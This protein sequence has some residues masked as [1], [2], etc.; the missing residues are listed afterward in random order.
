[1][2]EAFDFEYMD[3]TKSET[4]P[5]K[6]RE[7]TISATSLQNFPKST[8]EIR[9]TLP[10]QLKCLSSADEAS[11]IPQTVSV[12]SFPPDSLFTVRLR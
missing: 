9:P 10:D 2:S 6:S 11:A 7:R 1:M 3:A 12:E 8:R 5:R 4:V